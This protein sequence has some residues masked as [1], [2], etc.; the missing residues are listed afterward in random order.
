MDMNEPYTL[1]GYLASNMP[2]IRTG[3]PF[4]VWIS[5]SSGVTDHP[6]VWVAGRARSNDDLTVI[7]IEPDVHL[8]GDSTISSSEFE[9]VT[10]W[11]E[12]NRDV[13][14]RHWSGELFSGDAIAGI[15][16]LPTP[17]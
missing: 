16:S 15:K 4:V 12:L 5:V 14:V 11:I 6:C 3:L 1:D 17:A 8:I 7:A 9:R 13:L 2:P 10:E